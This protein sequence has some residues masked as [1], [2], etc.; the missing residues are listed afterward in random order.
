[1]SFYARGMQ[2]LRSAG[3]VSGRIVIVL[4]DSDA[5]IPNTF[6]VQTNVVIP[7]A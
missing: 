6:C 2:C 3:F 5:H 7:I 1:M 4:S